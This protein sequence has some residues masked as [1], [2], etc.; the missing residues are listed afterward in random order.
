[1]RRTNTGQLSEHSVAGA[2][3]AMI[4]GAGPDLKCWPFAFDHFL[5]IT[6]A[7]PSR[8]HAKTPFETLYGMKEDLSKFRT[9]CVQSLGSTSG[10]KSCQV[11]NKLTKG[12]LLLKDHTYKIMHCMNEGMYDQ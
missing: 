9:F 12:N 4:V 2:M 10:A 5:R 6:I 11:A 3:G 8:D 7:T 1:M